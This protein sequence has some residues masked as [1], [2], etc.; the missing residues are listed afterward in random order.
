M[1][2]RGI[3]LEAVRDR[4]LDLVPVLRWLP[5]YDRS[6]LKFDLVAGLTLAAFAIPDNM[7]YATLAG[8]PPQYGLYAGIMAPLAYFVFASSRHASVGPSSS[9]AI[10]VASFL[11]GLAIASPEEYAGVVALTALLVGVIALVAWVFRLGFLVNLI[12][13]PVMKGFLVGTGIVV[14]VSQ[15]P[16]L[17]GI[18]GAPPSFFGKII[19]IL[20]HLA[21]TNLYALALG[22]GSLLL[23][24]VL[25][26]RVPRLPGSLVVVALSI[27]LVWMADLADRGVEIVGTI[28][29]GLPAPG[30]PAFTL[31]DPSLVFPLAIGLFMLSF[32]EI[33]SIARTYAK[34]HDYEVDVDRELLALG[35]S[36]ISVGLT[37][38]FP[39][40]GSFSKTAVTDRSGAKT[41]LAGAVAAGVT[42][43]VVLLLTG[44]F[45]YLAE[46]VIGSLIIVAVFHMVDLSGLARIGHV[47][48]SEVYIALVTL[49][50]VLLFGILSGVLIGAGLSLL[51]IL[52]RFTFPNMVTVGRIPG[53]KLFGDLERH[54]ENIR[55][56]GTF[57]FR[58]EAPLIFANAESFRESFTRALGREERPIRLAIID[59]QRSPIIDVTAA[60]MI[61]GLSTDLGRRGIE[62]R[63]AHAS[64]R[65]RDLLRAAGI[66]ELVGRLDRTTTTEAICEQCSVDLPEDTLPGDPGGGPGGDSRER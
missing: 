40:G 12:S 59:L 8:L 66:E 22:L 13:G 15:V 20:Q 28:P 23:F 7:A 26:R 24:F 65:V 39:I 3:P 31:G 60:E 19:F 48:R 58:I 42:V 25:E 34:A 29:A 46:P 53:T 27:A 16:S 41:Q 55:I 4:L 1:D 50:G 44:A 2:L 6:W 38:G 47:N 35:A 43:L 57:I 54:P 10:M 56:P 30:L 21:E 49:G 62:L 63:L 45:Y 14:I 36:S 9:E 51:E 32:V 64:G 37:Q 52:Y 17:L 18:S 11:G 61:R 5:A 33:S